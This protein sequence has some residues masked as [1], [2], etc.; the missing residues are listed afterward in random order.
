MGSG[1]RGYILKV[2]NKILNTVDIPVFFKKA[3]IIAIIKPGKDE[4]EVNYYSS[5]SLLL[6]KRLIYNRIASVINK[7]LSKQ[8]FSSIKIL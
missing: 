2:Y 6:L 3:K 7:G 4:N 1:A 8:Q 5:I